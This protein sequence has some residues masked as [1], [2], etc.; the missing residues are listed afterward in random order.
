LG[1]SAVRPRTWRRAP[2]RS[3]RHDARARRPAPA[4]LSTEISGHHRATGGPFWWFESWENTEKTSRRSRRSDKPVVR[5]VSQIR[6]LPAGKWRAPAQ[7]VRFELSRWTF[8]ENEFLEPLSDDLKSCVSMPL[9]IALT[10]TSLRGIKRTGTPFVEGQ[11][12][13]FEERTV[14]PE[15]QSAIRDRLQE[16][17]DGGHGCVSRFRDGLQASLDPS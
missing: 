15:A 6:Y 10:I 16:R 3:R 1:E 11:S 17:F 13:D 8:A 2:S 12:S 7:R 9:P 5:D 4:M 14:I